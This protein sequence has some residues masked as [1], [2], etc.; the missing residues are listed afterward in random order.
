VIV[1]WY[2]SNAACY[3]FI[4][5]MMFVLLFALVGISVANEYPL[6]QQYMWV[7]A[8]LA[9]LSA[10]VILTTIFRL[11]KRFANLYSN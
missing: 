1:P 7:P 4:A 9:G 8:L 10:G 3:T 6:Y 5:C 2:D 11:V